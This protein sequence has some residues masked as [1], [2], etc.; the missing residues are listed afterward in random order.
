MSSSNAVVAQMLYRLA[1]LLEIGGESEFKVRAYR[2]AADRICVLPIQ[3]CEAHAGREDLAK[4]PGVGKSIAT[5]IASFIDTGTVELYEKLK[6]EIP[7]SMVELLRIRGLG[8]S[9][10]RQLH[11]AL[12]IA[13]V[14]QLR[15]ALEDGRLN[16]VKGFS[17]RSVDRIRR[18]MYEY[19][20]ERGRTLRVI[21]EPS[22]GQLIGYLKEGPAISQARLAGSFR[23]GRE[24]VRN[25]D[26][27][28]A[29]SDVD[30]AREY[31]LGWPQ[32]AEVGA[33]D[34]MRQTFTMPSG[35][36]VSVVIATEGTFGAAL[37]YHTGSPAH[38]F[39]IARLAAQ[40]DLRVEPFGLAASNRLMETPDETTFFATL[41]LPW[42]PP[43][44][45]EDGGEL[46]VAAAGE[47][48]ELIRPADIRGDLHTHTTFTDGKNTPREIVEL[49]REMGYEYIA[50]TDHTRNVA[51]ANGL[52]PHQAREYLRSLEELDAEF[53]DIAILKGLEVD[54]L[55]DGSLDMPDDILS[56]LDVVI[57]S[58]HSH[59]DQPGDQMTARVLAAL[60]NR[61]VH[62]L[63]HPTGRLI[64]Q[65]SP[66]LLDMEAVVK[67][68]AATGTMLELNSNPER[69][70]LSD[71]YCRAARDA[72]ILVVISTDAHNLYQL[73]N[74]R[75]GISQARRGWLTRD[76][77]LNTRPLAELKDLLARKRRR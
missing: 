48:P 49:A 75:R 51:I 74:M 69:L 47:L 42:I 8:P 63:G 23:R 10:V 31:V 35:T 16:Q 28:V 24:T 11:Q 60:E 39:R 56:R 36:E 17:Y 13:D 4:I 70:D 50:I 7:E 54:I 73:D 57:A 67:T 44:L 5:A 72:G 41:G 26:A 77:V 71:H 22:A 68:A 30:A 46:E 9:K 15:A 19:L 12:G 65:R 59:F 29:T 33:G 45:R 18:S 53:D 32:A 52:H 58:I 40:Q 20:G 76:N 6:R 21:A 37:H 27:V 38:V 1:G 14:E 43:E 55:A 25:I 34:A 61:W 3:L 62:V 66:L 2:L 64:G